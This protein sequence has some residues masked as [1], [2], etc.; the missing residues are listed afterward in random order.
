MKIEGILKMEGA[1]R[2]AELLAESGYWV[3]FYKYKPNP[4]TNTMRWCVEY[5]RE[6]EN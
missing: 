2:I 1:A 6:V 5:G 4:R 3:S